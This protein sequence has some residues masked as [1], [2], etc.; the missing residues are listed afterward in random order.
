MNNSFNNAADIL[1]IE[2]VVSVLTSGCSM[3]PMLRQHKDVVMVVRPNGK[4]RRGDV[5]LY[6]VDN[7]SELVLHRVIK[8]N[9]N[10]TYT[11]RGDNNYFTEYGIKSED[12]V[13]VLD[14][15][16]RGTEYIKCNDSAKYKLYKFYILNS[17][18]IRFFYKKSRL[19][20]LRNMP[21]GLKKFLKKLFKKQ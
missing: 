11:M 9:K 7:R 21:K 17:Y 3:Y 14:S 4:L 6:R 15:F 10:G 12:I 13:G 8:C 18:G 5:A 1:K 16:Y 2:P 20:I 19:F